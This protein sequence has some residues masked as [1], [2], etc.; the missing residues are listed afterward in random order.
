MLLYQI[1]AFNIPGIT[2][3]IKKYYFLKPLTPETIKFFGSPERKITQDRNDENLP[4]LKINEVVLA[5]CN[6]VNNIYQHDSRV[7]YTFV[8]NR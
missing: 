6:V 1:L 4:R 2:F 3:R 8:V 5:H 7:F